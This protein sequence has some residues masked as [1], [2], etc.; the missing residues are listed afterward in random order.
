MRPTHTANG[1]LLLPNGKMYIYL[2]TIVLAIVNIDIFI[3]KHIILHFGLIKISKPLA[4][5]LQIMQ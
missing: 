3:V 2:I 4:I 5:N 1:E